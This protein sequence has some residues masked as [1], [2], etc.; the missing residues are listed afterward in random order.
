MANEAQIR[1]WNE[2]GG[3]TWVAHEARQDIM[4]EPFDKV[5]LAAA[6]PQPGEH[7]L[8]VGCGFGTTTL[9]LARAVGERGRVMAL[10][11]SESMMARVRSRAAAEEI[12]N[13]ITRIGDAQT[14]V[15]PGGHFDLAVSRYG[16]MFFDDPVAAFGN[17]RESL[18][19]AGRLVFVCWQP[20][21][22]NEFMA[23]PLAAMRAVIG[24]VSAPAGVPGPFAF[25]DPELVRQILGDAGYQS[26][27]VTGVERPIVMGGGESI[28]AV[29][30]HGTESG[31]ARRALAEA[32]PEERA[33]A[34]DL[35]RAMIAARPAADRLT[36]MGASWL[37]TARAGTS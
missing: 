30:T 17:I 15:L 27:V 23:A 33:R 21:P 8:D 5:L 11:V 4:L 26:V 13:V 36:F 7:A 2:D 14:E 1:Y 34:R 19:P 31:P 18:R 35:V 3:P 37:V 6:A 16:V 28:D 10:D 12:T 22:V 9:E 25:S 20:L 32:T 24:P 29:V